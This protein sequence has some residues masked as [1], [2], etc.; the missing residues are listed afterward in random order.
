MYTAQCTFPN[1]STRPIDRSITFLTIDSN[2]VILP[3]KDSLVITLRIGGFDV[4]RILVDP[5]SSADLLQM[6]AY[7]QM[8]YYPF[9]LENPGCILTEF[10]GASTISLGY[11]IL[12]VQVG[13]VILNV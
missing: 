2:R 7:R 10:N 8:G 1:D 11:V 6:S 5:G 13:L 12:P 9:A 3:H 4:H